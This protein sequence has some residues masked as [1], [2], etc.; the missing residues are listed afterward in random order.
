[1]A[2]GGGGGGNGAAAAAAAELRL[3]VGGVVGLKYPGVVPRPRLALRPERPP[4]SPRSR[5]RSRVVGVSLD[6]RVDLPE[7]PTVGAWGGGRE[8]GAEGV[9][10]DNALEFGFGLEFIP[11]PAVVVVV[12]VVVVG[13]VVIPVA[14]IAGDAGEE[15]RSS[16]ESR[17]NS[18]RVVESVPEVFGPDGG[19]C[20]RPLS[21]DCCCWPREGPRRSWMEGCLCISSP[22]TILLI[23]AVVA[24]RV[25]AEAEAEVVFWVLVSRANVD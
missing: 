16:S 7:L 8:R 18:F 3:S 21:G 9:G 11:S 1:M 20:P 5:S 6:A 23:S 22:W 2:E 25:E 24:E 12:M 17:S 19:M 15:I 13:E 14:E 4:G 10:T